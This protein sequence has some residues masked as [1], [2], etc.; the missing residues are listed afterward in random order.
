M[1]NDKNKDFAQSSLIITADLKETLDKIVNKVMPDDDPEKPE[2][3][4][5]QEAAPPSDKQNTEQSAEPKQAQ[6]DEG[7]SQEETEEEE[8]AAENIENLEATAAG[9]GGGGSG[10]SELP[11]AI[12]FG[13]SGDEESEARDLSLAPIKFVSPHEDQ[14]PFLVQLSE[15]LPPLV[16]FDN[17]RIIGN[18]Y[19]ET[20]FV[21]DFNTRREKGSHS[22]DSN[23][24]QG[25]STSGHAQNIKSTAFFSTRNIHETVTDEDTLASELNLS[26][27]ILDDVKGVDAIEGS[28]MWYDLKLAPGQTISFDYFFATNESGENGTDDKNFVNV[29]VN[30][31]F[32]ND[33][34]FISISGPSGEMIYSF[35]DVYSAYNWNSAFIDSTWWAH[36]TGWNSSSF[37]V[38][39]TWDVGVYRIGFGVMDVGSPNQS[40]EDASMLQIDNIRSCL[41]ANMVSGNVINDP[42]NYTDSLDPLGSIDIPEGGSRVTRIAFEYGS[43]AEDFI[44]YNNLDDFGAFVENG[45]VVIPI[46]G[47]GEFIDI[48]TP[49]YNH[50]VINSEGDY[51]YF[52]S[53]SKSGCN[54][55]GGEKERTIQED[56]YDGPE[57][58]TY[59][60][61]DGT[62]RFDEAFL[63]ITK[64]NADICKTTYE[65]DRPCA[66]L[67]LA[68]DVSGSMDHRLDIAQQAAVSLVQQYLFLGYVLDITVV[69]FSSGS[70]TNN[71]YDGALVYHASSSSDAISY[72]NGLYEG[73]ASLGFNTEYDD[74]LNVMQRDV[75]TPMLKK[76]CNCQPV[77]YVM[78][79]GDPTSGQGANNAINDWQEFVDEKNINVIA[80]LIDPDDLGDAQNAVEPV[81]NDGDVPVLLSG[82]EDIEMLLDAVIVPE[83]PFSFENCSLLWNVNL[84]VGGPYEVI[85]ITIHF[86]ADDVEPV[87]LDDLL[88]S[89]NALSATISELTGY[90][91]VMVDVPQ[92]GFIDILSPLGGLLRVERDGTYSYRNPY[93]NAE[94]YLEDKFTFTYRDDELDLQA[95]GQLCITIEDTYPIAYDNGG[96]ISV[97]RDSTFIS[98]FASSK[99]WSESGHTHFPFTFSGSSRAF[100]STHDQGFGH[101]SETSENSLASF[102][103]LDSSILDNVRSED[104]VEGAA[105]KRSY[106]LEGGQVIQFDYYFATNDPNESYT[107]DNDYAFLSLTGN[108]KQIVYDFADANSTPDVTNI[109][110]DSLVWSGNTGWQTGVFVVPYDWVAGNYVLG[111]GVMDVGFPSFTSGD[112]SM[113]MVDNLS[114]YSPPERIQ[115]NVITDPNSDYLDSADPINAVDEIRADG[116]YVS[117]ISFYVDGS[118]N[119]Y[120]SSHNLDDLVGAYGDGSVVYVPVDED[121]VSFETYWGGYLSIDQCGDYTYAG[122]YNPE[123]NEEQFMYTLSERDGND[124]DTA[125]L[126]FYFSDKL[127]YKI[128]QNG[129]DHKE[130]SID[131]S[132]KPDQ[133]ILSG[134]ESGDILD[135]ND[136]SDIDDPIGGLGQ[137]D[138]ED[139]LNSWVQQGDDVVMQLQN[140]SVLVLQG[141]GTVTGSGTNSD[142]LNYL[143]A[144]MNVQINVNG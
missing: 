133:F 37:T 25:W 99:G 108:G 91:T 6:G 24:F 28:A 19:C 79:D 86:N 137:P 22:S 69:P 101:N 58:F 56:K 68:I 64:V 103:G 77:V 63:V 14:P 129:D 80:V 142:L 120:I 75:L 97:E 143:D 38:P 95:N 65:N 134:L 111:F 136:V 46:P 89:Y 144:S 29:V 76:D 100:L 98:N 113:L 39:Y 126:T 84:D 45:F 102:L 62:G 31:V 10:G 48:I 93:M 26:S 17:A 123:T 66:N 114:F 34:A 125:Y 139:V 67:V 141:V 15:E 61:E 35:A 81:G 130:F 85:K 36:N 105:I 92:D 20:Q 135:F 33:Y 11:S 55:C 115:G 8:A 43:G 3:K 107:D 5:N 131:L 23:Y 118:A 112:A 2:N 52:I 138:F 121:G 70:L 50:L 124:S 18:C 72:I 44:D 117:L 1:S 106:Y 90:Y 74:L 127:D 73:Y 21:F 96:Y 116:G 12:L 82:M 60:L 4:N 57:K 49:Q 13:R 110:I 9:G 16:A 7:A 54:C 32:N 78:T 27:N 41:G 83:Q 109:T 42:N 47:D 59:R 104:A 51:R 40:T 94:D 30:N 87:F 128:I 53:C 122:P 119:S 88:D 140:Y 71:L 132:D